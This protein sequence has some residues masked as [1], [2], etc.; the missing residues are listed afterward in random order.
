MSEW[1]TKPWGQKRKVKIKEGYGSLAT[2]GPYMLPIL[3]PFSIF[4]IFA[5]YSI[6]FIIILIRTLGTFLHLDYCDNLP[7]TSSS[8]D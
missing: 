8:L 5:L 1:W 2:F 7:P 3:L 4:L 6:L